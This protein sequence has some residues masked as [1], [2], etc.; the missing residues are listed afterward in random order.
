LHLAE[1]ARVCREA[2]ATADVV[3][4]FHCGGHDDLLRAAPASIRSTEVDER[5]MARLS[6]AATPPGILAV[7]RTPETARPL[8]ETGPLLVLDGVSD[9][10]N[11]GTLLRTAAAFGV[12]VVSVGGADPF[13]PKAVRASAG[14][15]YRTAVH[16]VDA[17][18][19]LE[20]QLR[21][22]GRV[23]LG[24]GADGGL[25]LEGAVT[26]VGSKDVVLVVGSEPHGLGEEVRGRIDDL[27]R[28]PMV[29]GVESLNVAAA[30]AIAVHALMRR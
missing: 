4:M 6:D 23:V 24:L 3:E 5:V 20:A 1:G 2:L 11:V 8:P 21:G 28:I 25:T 16:R 7:V 26:R 9:P 30:G 18:G 17:P 12:A 15:C 29:D 10:G 14:T 13:G 19:S 22:A 27:V